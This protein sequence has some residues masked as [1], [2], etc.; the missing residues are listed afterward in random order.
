MAV[1][2]RRVVVELDDRA[3]AASLSSPASAPT[4]TG[5]PAPAACA[6]TSSS[7][8]RITLWL[9]A[10][11]P[12]FLP[13]RDQR[14]ESSA[15]RCRSCPRPAVPGWAARCGRDRWRCGR[16]TP[17]RSRPPAS[18]TA[19][20]SQAR[21]LPAQ[22]LRAALVSAGHACARRA[23]SPTSC[24]S[25]VVTDVCTKTPRVGCTSAIFGPFDVDQPRHAVVRHDV[26]ER[27]LVCSFS[28][29]LR[30]ISISCSG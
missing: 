17:A 1:E 16:R 23:A 20:R 13:A 2:R 22:Q 26:A 19:P 30:P 29:P 5:W 4:F 3:L 8:L 12:T 28:L 24:S 15:R 18:R 7:R 25:S 6:I 10:V 21:R 27:R 11:T 14:A 9:V